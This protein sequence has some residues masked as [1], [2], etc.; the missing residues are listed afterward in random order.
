[1]QMLTADEKVIDF[2]KKIASQVLDKLNLC[3][4]IKGMN[5]LGIISRYD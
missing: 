1:M 2:Y 3:A 4:F 5:D